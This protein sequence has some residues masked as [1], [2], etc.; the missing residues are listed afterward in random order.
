VP[1]KIGS[2]GRTRTYNPPVNSRMLKHGALVHS[3]TWLERFDDFGARAA[4]NV[5]QNVSQFFSRTG[6][7]L[8]AENRSTGTNTR[9]A[10]TCE[11]WRRTAKNSRSLGFRR[12]KAESCWP[13]SQ[14]QAGGR[15]ASKR[16][17]VTEP[18]QSPKHARL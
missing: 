2:S 16:I 17:G 6:S 15:G 9:I 18:K 14:V 3:M 13:E 10:A 11:P 1:E 7:T 8:V 12:C 5:S 4:H